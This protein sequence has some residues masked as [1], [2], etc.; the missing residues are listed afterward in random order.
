MYRDDQCHISTNLLH[1]FLSKYCLMKKTYSLAATPYAGV[2]PNIKLQYW[3]I[4]QTLFWFIGII[5]LL[6]MFFEPSVGTMLFWNILIPAA[7]A[8]LVVASGVWRNICPLATTAL[9]PDRFGLS[10]KKKL[11]VSQRNWFNL[12]GVTALFLIIPLRHVLFNNNGQATAFI[13]IL[14]GIAALI[15]GFVYERKSAWCSGLCPIH[16]VEKLYGTGVAFTVPNAQCNECVKCSVPC[17]DS[18]PN[19]NPLTLKKSVKSKA[20]EYMIVGAFPG[21]IWGWF[22]VPD[23]QPGKGWKYLDIVYGYPVMGAI[24][25]LILYL[26]VIE[27]SGHSKRKQIVNIFAAAAVSC[28]YWFRLPLLFGFKKV[29]FISTLVDLSNSLPYWSMT[30]LNLLTTAFFVWWIVIRKKTKRSWSI[31]P[32]Y[33]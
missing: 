1:V 31:R 6:I 15:T 5:L 17:P 26:F 29:N 2:N 14:L 18:T 23:F 33:A 32:E 7:P 9:L 21:Y 27:L 12:A 4:I 10:K 11:S 22:Q 13:I 30:V 28:Y 19:V 24:A 8:L 16:G 25:T 20:I 3:K